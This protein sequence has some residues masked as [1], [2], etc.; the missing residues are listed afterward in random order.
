[1][2]A[3]LTR[4]EA[5]IGATAGLL[6]AGWSRPAPAQGVAGAPTV[7]ELAPDLALIEGAGANVIVLATA[8]GLLLVD[9]GAAQHSAALMRVLAERWPGRRV[10]ILF[11][12]NWREEHT[13][14]NAA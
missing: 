4:R 10:E 6:A 5:L 2:G 13:G 7:T 11:N 8:D 3:A 14:A 9:G 12:S 1:M